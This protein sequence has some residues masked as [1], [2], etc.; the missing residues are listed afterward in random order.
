ML[1]QPELDSPRYEAAYRPSPAPGLWQR[2]RYWMDF[3]GLGSTVQNT[4]CY[5][6]GDAWDG[7]EPFD[8]LN[9]WR[10]GDE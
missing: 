5:K 4:A 10:C 7:L 9:G 3:S 8:M 1:T 2:I 6:N